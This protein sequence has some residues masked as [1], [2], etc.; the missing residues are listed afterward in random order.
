[1]PGSAQEFFAVA[2]PKAASDL[3]AALRRLPEEKRNV[4]PGGKA[5]TPADLVAE[6]AI[7]N[8]STAEML[9]TYKF[10]SF[11]PGAYERQRDELCADEAKL[12]AILHENTARAVAAMREVPDADLDIEIAMPWGPVTVAQVVSYPFWNMGYHEGQ[13]N[14]LAA[15]LGCLD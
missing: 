1:M 15:M 6:C 3:E 10:P 12:I 13:I 5:R 14:Y 4:S 2:S 7:L 8:G 11:D 9:K